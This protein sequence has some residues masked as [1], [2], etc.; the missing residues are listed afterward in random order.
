MTYPMIIEFFLPIFSRYTPM[1][2]EI[3][4]PPISNALEIFINGVI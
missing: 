1:M 3:M 4:S 2:G